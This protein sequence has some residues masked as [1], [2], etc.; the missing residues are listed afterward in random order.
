MSNYEEHD[1][2]AAVGRLTICTSQSYDICS[3]CLLLLA[4]DWE[5]VQVRE[6]CVQDAH[7]QQQHKHKR[8]AN[9]FD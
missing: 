3:R 6:A 9:V 1:P 4:A 8:Q 2:C 7:L 5:A